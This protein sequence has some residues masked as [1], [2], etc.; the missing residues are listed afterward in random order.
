MI[1]KN[2]NSHKKIND[3][4]TDEKVPSYKRDMYPIVTDDRGEIIWIPGIKK[5]YLDKTKDKKYDIILK[6]N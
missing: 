4:F 5:S 6:Y 2:M 1:V 3:I